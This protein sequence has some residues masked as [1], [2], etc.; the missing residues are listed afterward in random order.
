[1][2]RLRLRRRGGGPAGGVPTAAAAKGKGKE[3]G[4]EAENARKL[5]MGSNRRGSGQREEID[6][7]PELR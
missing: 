2:G 3:V 1:M 5:T 7:R 6:A 4:K